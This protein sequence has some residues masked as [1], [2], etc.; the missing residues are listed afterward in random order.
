MGMA[1]VS[2]NGRE[3][4]AN[5]KIKRDPASAKL[6]PAPYFPSV[7]DFGHPFNLQTLEKII[8]SREE[9]GEVIIQAQWS[10]CKDDQYYPIT[11]FLEVMSLLKEFDRRYP[12]RMEPE[13]RR[14]LDNDKLVSHI[15]SR[16][17]YR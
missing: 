6:Q 2:S 10:M 15:S 4:P 16:T 11:M 12:G 14:R 13:W 3:Y 1:L 8:D 17:I 5:A 7:S 9:D